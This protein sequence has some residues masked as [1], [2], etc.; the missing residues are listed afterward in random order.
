MQ[1]QTI[2]NVLIN[3]P[4]NFGALYEYYPTNSIANYSRN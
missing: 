2:K 4:N 1:L 3:D